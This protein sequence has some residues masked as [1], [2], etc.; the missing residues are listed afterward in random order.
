MQGRV[1]K[2][3][4]FFAG[5]GGIRLG[6][7]EEGFKTVFANDFDLTCKDTYDLNFSTVPLFIQDIN[8]LK[9]DDIKPFDILL[10]GFPCQPFSIAGYRKGFADKERGELFF[11]I[12]EILKERKPKALLLENVKNLKSHNSGNTFKIIKEELKKLGY[13]VK[14]EILNTMKHGNIPQNRERVYIVGFLSK[15]AFNA[16][17]F[18]KEVALTKKVPDLLENKVDEKYYY[19]NGTLFEELNKTIKSK[20]IIYQWRRVYVRENKN[21]VCPTLTANMGMG[22]HNVPIVKDDFGIRKLT[23]RECA[24]FQGFPDDF[25]LPKIADSKLYKQLGN[26]V[27]VPVISRIAKSMKKAIQK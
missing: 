11:K 4:D 25:K 9:M 12:L 16:F 10:G 15:K 19:K 7:E 1:L 23:P 27:S 18:P 3:A 17:S 13:Y 5:I 8:K 20:N 24:R 26:S 21:G 14:D 6:F 2:T 22:G